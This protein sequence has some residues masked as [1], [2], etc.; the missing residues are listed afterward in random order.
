MSIVDT[1]I[2]LGASGITGNLLVIGGAFQGVWTAGIAYLRGQVITS[3]GNLYVCLADNT[4]HQPP[5]IAFWN[6]INVQGPQGVPGPIGPAGS[7]FPLLEVVAEPG[8]TVVLDVLDTV[9]SAQ[10]VIWKVLIH[11]SINNLTL[12]Y[13]IDVLWANS[14][15]EYSI[16][17]MKGVAIPIDIS[18]SVDGGVI[19]LEAT[20]SAVVDLS[21]KLVKVCHLA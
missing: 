17:S 2:S 14:S 9:P 10:S 11:D 6:I 18:F 7:G 16:Y 13:T 21:I 12:A 8:Q 4:D 19:S 20:S 1:I 5:D 15:I 3:D